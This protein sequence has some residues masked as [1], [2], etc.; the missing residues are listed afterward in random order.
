M[1][2]ITISRQSTP[3]ELAAEMDRRGTVIETLEKQFAEFVER[4]TADVQYWKAR[5]EAAEAKV[6]ELTKRVD[7]LSTDFSDRSVR[8]IAAE[9]KVVELERWVA[10]KDF[11]AKAYYDQVAAMTAAQTADKFTILTLRKTKDEL[12]DALEASDRTAAAL[13][14]ALENIAKADPVDL[15]LDPEWPQRVALAALD[16]G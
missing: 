13:R 8:A 11:A 4:S 7:E 9:A 1:S 16:E 10:A 14:T 2:I 3:D 15:A 5:A 6:G 12:D